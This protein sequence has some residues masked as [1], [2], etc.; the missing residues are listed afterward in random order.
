MEIVRIL[1]INQQNHRR[2]KMTPETLKNKKLDSYHSGCVKL[3]DVKS[4][5]EWMIQIHEERIEELIK[6]V[7]NNI[8]MYEND[9]LWYCDMIRKEYESFMIL[10][11]GLEDVI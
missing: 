8:M 11:A 10:E 5:L 1:N 4:A 6:E 2:F 7:G 9:S 3:H